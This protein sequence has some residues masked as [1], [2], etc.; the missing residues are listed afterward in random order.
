MNKV[1]IS[2]ELHVRG[3]FL[4]QSSAP[5]PYGLDAVLARDSNGQIYIPG[6]HVI[7]KLREAWEELRKAL[8]GSN[9]YD[10]VPTEAEIKQLLGDRPKPADSYEPRAK[11]LLFSDFTLQGPN[12]T[13]RMRY[14][15][16][17]DP[18]RG[19]VK[20]G[21]QQMLESPFGA[22]ETLVFT[23]RLTF[24]ANQEDESASIRQKVLTGLQWV[25][26][27]GAFRGIGFGRL[28]NV[29]LGE[30]A[31]TPVRIETKPRSSQ[32][33]FDIS[34]FPEAPFCLAQKP[35]GSNLFESSEEIPGGV[36]KGCL[37]SALNRL[38]GEDGNEVKEKDDAFDQLRKHFP[39]VRISHAFPS[40]ECW[41]RPV[42]PPLSLVQAGAVFDVA[43]LE[44]PALVNGQAP[45]FAIDWK[46]GGGIR[47]S[48]GWPQVKRELR[49]RTAIDAGTLRSQDE[50]LFAYNMVVPDGLCWQARVTLDKETINNQT[51]RRAVM[52]Q[53]AALLNI[54][55]VGLGRTKATAR[56]AIHPPGTI[57]DVLPTD[58]K[59]TGMG[60]DG[61]LIITLQTPALLCSPKGLLEENP[62]PGALH[63]AY[64]ECWKDL[65]PELKL[66][67]FFASQHLEGGKYQ[68]VRFGKTPGKY[69]P[70]LL[71]DAGSV[72]VFVVKEDSA[73]DTVG[74]W[75]QTGL[76]LGEPIIDWYKQF[77]RLDE[78][79]A[80]WKGCPYVPENGYGE[81]AVNLPV[82]REWDTHKHELIDMI[83]DSEEKEDG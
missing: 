60:P 76:P 44:G 40:A 79:S 6:S 14:R 71:T 83:T 50:Q 22:G 26:Q 47:S 19:A 65:C 10:Q 18:R 17:I 32:S 25:P 34:I 27:L 8:G 77:Y 24:L 58:R 61:L 23:G 78:E 56:V 13:A 39:A 57:T 51:D 9:A 5:G 63:K 70:W 7:G 11:R 66:V 38:S 2:I 20:Q 15:I 12:R 54:G 75:L 41:Q 52:D 33:A 73:L 72:F 16:Q 28:E 80:C 35:I 31:L 49:V 53:L 43:L 62:G 37:A 30:P 67:R 29:R 59:E 48:F 46:D 1:D 4:T 42:H 74:R 3:P 21:A 82:H 69:Y 55:I 36:L 68:H 64:K 81:I 45:A